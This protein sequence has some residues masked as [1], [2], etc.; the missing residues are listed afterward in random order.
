MLIL[1]WMISWTITENKQRWNPTSLSSVCGSGKPCKTQSY[2]KGHRIRLTFFSFNFSAFSSFSH[3]FALLSICLAANCVKIIITNLPILM[4][5]TFSNT[6]FLCQILTSII[7]Y[8]MTLSL[9][10]ITGPR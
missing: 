7:A 9:H 2:N 6:F 5:R 1:G 10:R 8:P 3:F 4:L